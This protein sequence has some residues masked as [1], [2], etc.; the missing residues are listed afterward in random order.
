MLRPIG[1]AHGMQLRNI[2]APINRPRPHRIGQ[3]I[4]PFERHRAHGARLGDAAAVQG[5]DE[6]A[7]FLG[8]IRQVCRLP[9]ATA[10]RAVGD[11][12]RLL[13]FLAFRVGIKPARLRRPQ[14]Q[15]VT[16]L[17]KKLARLLAKARTCSA[18]LCSPSWPFSM[19]SPRKARASAAVSSLPPS[20][21]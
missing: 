18:K 2:G 13:G 17:G 1:P 20:E 21:T 5:G 16:G 8:D 12:A 3:E 10:Q 7:V 6:I 4:R 9:E 11:P 14:D 19:F 15:A